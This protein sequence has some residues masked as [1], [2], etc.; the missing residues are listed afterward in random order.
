MK[1]KSP[2]DDNYEKLMN[3]GSPEEVAKLINE[4]FNYVVDSELTDME[5]GVLQ[6]LK[7]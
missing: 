2:W 3:A 5:Q 1:E 4:A 6:W 7:E